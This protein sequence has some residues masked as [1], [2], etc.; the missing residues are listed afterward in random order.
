MTRR[1]EIVGAGLTGATIA[2]VLWDNG[3]RNVTVY[4]RRG[5]VGGNCHDYLH[6][7]GITIGSH[8][9]HY[10]RTNSQRIWDFVHRFSEFREFAAVIRAK[11]G[12][13]I[14]P[15]PVTKQM[16]GKPLKANP[17]FTSNFETACLSRMSGYCYDR[18]VAPYTRKQW[19]VNPSKLSADLA[20]RIEIR[21][22][23]DERLKTS[24]FQAIPV[25][26][27][28]SLITNMLDGIP[29][30]LQSDWLK[31]GQLVGEDD[32]VVFT[33]PIDEFFGYSLGK[34]R[35]RTQR[36]YSEYIPRL[37]GNAIYANTTV[38][39]NHPD[40]TEAYVRVIEWK[41]MLSL[42]QAI[43]TQGTVL[44]VE[45]PD[46]A[47]DSDEYEY[48]YPDQANRDLYWKYVKA[49]EAVPQVI[50]AGR[51]GRYQYMDMDQAIGSALAVA[52]KLVGVD[53]K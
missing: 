31:D 13:E 12:G 18:F 16:A 48:P 1:W 19:G 44:T 50:F 33:G 38:Q 24:K 39:V 11:S 9:P 14:F 8:G 51:L 20:N 17:D 23:Q 25:N 22:G 10:F 43:Q 26:G 27:Y 21:D 15:W 47:S 6:P 28:T 40:H 37:R 30:V 4:E 45:H 52:N 5:V 46:D 36:R 2:R 7:S 35:Y 34:L 49:A 3:E 32:V 53:V 41:H 42:E 29:V